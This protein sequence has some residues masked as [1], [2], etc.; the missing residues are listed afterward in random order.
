M[1]ILTTFIFLVYERV[2]WIVLLLMWTVKSLVYWVH[3][4]FYLKMV[5]IYFLLLDVHGYNLCI[6]KITMLHTLFSGNQTIGSVS[7]PSATVQA[8]NSMTFNIP[9]A[10]KHLLN[11]F[12]CI[13]DAKVAQNNGKNPLKSKSFYLQ[14]SEGKDFKH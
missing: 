12:Y 14:L 13:I 6:N 5:C 9:V 8:M 3:Q 11:N 4:Q 7:S 1:I 2:M 10:D